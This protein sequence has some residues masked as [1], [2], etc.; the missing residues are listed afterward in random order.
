MA[1]DFGDGEE[2][3]D[4]FG[5]EELDLEELDDF[6]YALG[7]AVANTFAEKRGLQQL[8][9]DEEDDDEEVRTQQPT[10]GKFNYV[11]TN[12]WKV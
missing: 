7:P 2:D 8:E 6:N 11:T 10:I 5:F 1:A 3:V 9:E 12:N 4:G